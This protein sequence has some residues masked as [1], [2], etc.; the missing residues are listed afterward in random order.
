MFSVSAGH[1]DLLK[2]INTSFQRLS[3]PI[4]NL[5]GIP[6][7]TSKSSL[8]DLIAKEVAS[9]AHDKEHHYLEGLSGSSWTTSGMYLSLRFQFCL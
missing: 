6:K 5:A 4:E 1:S 3:L 8:Q 9:P 7:K 2:N